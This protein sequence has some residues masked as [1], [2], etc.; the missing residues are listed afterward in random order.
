MSRLSLIILNYNSAEDTIT[1][2][3]QLSSLHGGWHLI[4]VDN[5]STDNSLDRIRNELG[6]TPLLDILETKK[7]GGYSAGNNVGLRYAI[8]RYGSDTVGIINPDVIVP[9]SDVIE[10]MIQC[11]WS[12]SEFAVCGAS[13]INSLHEYNPN[14]SSWDIPSRWR[15]VRDHAFGKKRYERA[16]NILVERGNYAIVECVAGCFFIAKSSVLQEIGLLDEGV[17]LYNEEN[18][19]GWKLRIRGYKE[20]LVLDQFYIHNHRHRADAKRS[21]VQRIHNAKAGYESRKYFC[22]MAYG[23][24][25]LPLL[26][27]FEMYNRIIICMG[28]LKRLLYRAFRGVGVS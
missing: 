21:L 4:V 23:N 28:A 17:F 5:C 19:L 22:K 16:R 27:L 12:R 26:A 18:I 15:T 9:S 8:N 6:G 13:T 7:N 25:L 20:V 11:L 2:V 14:Y 3:R 10:K 1:C 24:V